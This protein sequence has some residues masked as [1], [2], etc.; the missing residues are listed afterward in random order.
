MK[1]DREFRRAQAERKKNKFRKIISEEWGTLHESQKDTEKRIAK[2]AITPKPN[3]CQC[4]CN[5]RHSSWHTEDEK[6]TMQ[7]RR[8]KR[9]AEYAMKDY[10]ST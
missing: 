4:C 7:E 1:R 2:M 10:L 8:A 5:P 6:L 3:K 9:E